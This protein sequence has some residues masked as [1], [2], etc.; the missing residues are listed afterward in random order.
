MHGDYDLAPF[1]KPKVNLTTQLSDYKYQYSKGIY[2]Y[3]YEQPDADL[4]TTGE[5]KQNFKSFM[6]DIRQK[7]EGVFDRSLDENA[8]SLCEAVL[9]GDKQALSADVR[10]DFTDTGMSYLIVVSGMHLAIVTFLLRRL[11]NRLRVNR[12]ITFAALAVFVLFF[13]LS[14]LGFSLYGLY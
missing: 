13:I 2:L 10:Q 3:A 4:V 5:K 14:V 6:F 8:A 11:L 1:D 7:M 9:L 12:W